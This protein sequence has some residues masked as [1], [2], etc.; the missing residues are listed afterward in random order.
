MIRLLILPLLGLGVLWFMIWFRRTPP[1]RVADTLR[2][3]ILWAVVGVLVLACVQMTTFVSGKFALVKLV[4]V[5]SEPCAAKVKATAQRA[6]RTVRAVAVVE[7]KNHAER[8]KI[9]VTK[10]TF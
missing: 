6:V 7:H 1:A 5:S 9:L 3:V 8:L 4:N 2:K 10:F